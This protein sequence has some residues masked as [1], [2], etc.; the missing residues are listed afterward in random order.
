MEYKGLKRTHHFVRGAQAYGAVIA[1]LLILLVILLSSADATLGGRLAGNTVL[2]TTWAFIFALGVETS[3]ILSWVRVGTF[4]YDKKYWQLTWAIPLALG[5]TYIAWQPL[6][7]SQLQS[8]MGV[9]F[10]QA[11]SILGISMVFFIVIRSLVAVSL[12]A[13][14]AVSNTI[15][16]IAARPTGATVAIDQATVATDEHVTAIADVT[17]P[18]AIPE[19]STAL[20]SP[21]YERIREAMN[22]ATVGGILTVSLKDIATH[23]QVGHSTV[24]KHAPSIKAELG[25][26]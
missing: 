3:F 9:S 5:L 11:L 12:G 10:N 23:A 20:H 22:L 2:T 1:E 21:E 14:L 18:V 6:E 16:F 13:V 26:A 25:I 8:S 7:I 24:K 17:E 19:K 4:L 15:D